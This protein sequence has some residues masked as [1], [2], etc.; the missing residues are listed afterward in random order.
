MG[1]EGPQGPTGPAGANGSNGATGASSTTVF[2][3]S[4]GPSTPSSGSSNPPAGWSSTV[5]GGSDPVW[6]SVG[7]R[8]AGSSTWVWSEPK[9]SAT[10]WMKPST[11]LIDGN[12]IFT[13]DA[14]V[15]TLQ[16][17]GQAVSVPAGINQDTY[18]TL[19]TDWQT[20]CS[21][22]VDVGS[23]AGAPS[24]VLVSGFH[25]YQNTVP[26][27]TVYDIAMR[28]VA[29]GNVGGAVAMTHQNQTAVICSNHKF[30]GISGT[31][32]FEIQVK[33]NASDG[34]YLARNSGLVIQGVKR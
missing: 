22:Y 19:T 16:I 13:G 14:Y 21:T 7:N 28:L 27:G 8:D 17:K 3:R 5:P 12:K 2:I 6:E 34:T 15:D 33:K 31:V 11:T 1:P 10:H 24:A 32:L 20:V 29:G 30:S 26:T 9:V 25:N 23:G 4:T 18:T